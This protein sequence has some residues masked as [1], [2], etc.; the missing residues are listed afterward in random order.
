MTLPL[1]SR[2]AGWSLVLCLAANAP[3]RAQTAAAGYA[4]PALPLDHLV[5]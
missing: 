3:L 1:L 5:V 2:L 4:D